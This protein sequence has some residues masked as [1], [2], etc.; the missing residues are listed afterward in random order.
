MHRGSLK[1]IMATIAAMISFA[2]CGLEEA[3]Q[4]GLSLKDALGSIPIGAALA[5]GEYGPGSFDA[6]S[7]Y[8]D[9]LLREFTSV[10]P[11]NCM[12]PS[13]IHP[14]ESRYE[15]SYA[16][17]LVEHAMARSQKLRGHTLVWHQQTPSFFF[18]SDGTAEQ[19]RSYSMSRMK[20]HIETV[21]KRYKGRVY[22]W[23]VVNEAIS[24]ASGQRY[25][26]DSPWYLAYGGPGY[27]R[28]A[29]AYARAADSDALLFY[30]DYSVVDPAKRQKILDM[31]DELDLI[32]DGLIDGVGLQGHWRMSWPSASAIKDTIDAFHTKGLKVHVTELDIDCY[33]GSTSSAT[34]PY[35]EFEDALAARYAEVFHAFREMGG[36]LSSVTF[37]G[38]A[39]DH[40]WLDHFYNNRWN[41][42]PIR[43]NYPLPFDT[44]GKRKKAYYGILGMPY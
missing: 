17:R 20:S 24:D 4:D 22:C 23:D 1:A 3:P 30:N 12:K 5:A 16:D 2:A 11:E 26:E 25:R 19:K 10:T 14:S 21:M 36:K 34:R 42:T 32:E 6:L 31:I 41:E 38:V 37:W 29:F 18:A 9:A 8:P 33:D 44:E 39:D 28:E 35:A 27:I 13:V 43:K 40:T 15:W 7:A